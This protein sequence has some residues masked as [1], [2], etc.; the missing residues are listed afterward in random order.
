VSWMMVVVKWRWFLVE[1]V[2]DE[3]TACQTRAQGHGFQTILFGWLD[4]L[5]L[6]FFLRQ[7]SSFQASLGG[8]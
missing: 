7:A 8:A 1:V 2:F 6:F 4:V 3:P 5:F